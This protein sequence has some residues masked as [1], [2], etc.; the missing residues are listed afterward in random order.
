M[1]VNDHG[2]V[3]ADVVRRYEAAHA[4]E[5]HSSSPGVLP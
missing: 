3:P 2:R 4:T 5:P 1:A